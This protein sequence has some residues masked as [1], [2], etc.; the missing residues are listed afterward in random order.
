MA[1]SQFP[2][3]IF[4]AGIAGPD[5]DQLDFVV[6]EFIHDPHDKVQSLVFDE[7][8]D[9]SDERYA[10]LDAKAEFSPQ[11]VFIFPFVRPGCGYGV[12]LFNVRSVS[13]L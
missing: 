4:I 7:A 8:R 1:V 2:E 6:D 12:L 13:G 9:H 11:G 3:G 10:A 5:Q